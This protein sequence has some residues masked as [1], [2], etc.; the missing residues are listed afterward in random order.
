VGGGS[1]NV[2][3]QL[4]GDQLLVVPDGVENLTDRQGRGGVLAHQP[5]RL[6][7][8]GGGAVLQ[9]EEVVRLQALAELRR[10]DRSEAMMGVV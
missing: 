6:L 4:L 1:A 7:V 2:V 8:L 9:P 3:D 5:Q 10:L